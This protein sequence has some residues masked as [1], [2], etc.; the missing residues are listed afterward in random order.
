M[1]GGHDEREQTLNALL[2][3]MDGF[4]AQGGLS[5]IAATNRPDTLDPAILR[6][7]RFDRHI[8]VHLADIKMYHPNITYDFIFSNP[9]FFE[10]DLEAVNTDRNIARHAKHLSLEELM[11]Q[12]KRLLSEVGEVA[13]IIPSHRNAVLQNYAKEN[14]LYLKSN[15][16][17]RH[18][19]AKLFTKEVHVYSALPVQLYLQE[20]TIK[21]MDG[22]YTAMMQALM[23][24]FYL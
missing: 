17:I 21:E 16:K 18:H 15:C 14:Q 4:D 9:P 19:S 10:N 23:K 22:N 13:I 2:V 8:V 5:L 3:E 7:G 24:E 20:F 12:C 1:G 6:P 11:V